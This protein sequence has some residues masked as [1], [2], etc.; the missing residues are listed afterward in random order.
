MCVC[1]CVEVT[2]V[3]VSVRGQSSGLKDDVKFEMDPFGVMESGC[4]GSLLQTTPRPPAMGD[5]GMAAMVCT[6]SAPSSPV[7]EP[8]KT[9][10]VERDVR[11]AARLPPS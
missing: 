2:A 3:R 5:G 11:T 8:L 10:D 9:K 4:L 1:M 6:G 7:D